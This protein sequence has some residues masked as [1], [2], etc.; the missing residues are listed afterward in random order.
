MLSQVRRTESR[1]IFDQN[2]LFCKQ[3][4]LVDGAHYVT[5][6]VASFKYEDFDLHVRSPFAES[7]LQLGLLFE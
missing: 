5:E 1:N 2:E 4:K 7:G 6:R 3:V